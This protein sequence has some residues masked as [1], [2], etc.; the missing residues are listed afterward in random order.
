M[1][2][3]VVPKKLTGFSEMLTAFIITLVMEAVRTSETSVIFTG[4]HGA[5]SQNTIIFKLVA[6]KT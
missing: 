4:L 1:L 2:R 3:L 6:L 5:T